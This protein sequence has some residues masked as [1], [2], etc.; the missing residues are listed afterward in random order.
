MVSQNFFQFSFGTDIEDFIGHVAIY[1]SVNKMKNMARLI[2]YQFVELFSTRTHL[3]KYQRFPKFSF[4]PKSNTSIFR[5][6]TSSSFSLFSLARYQRGCNKTQHV[7]PLPALTTESLDHHD[8]V[9]P[10]MTPTIRQ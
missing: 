5:C 1:R 4:S 3:Y 8:L 9:S 2:Y 6:F 7:S 10:E